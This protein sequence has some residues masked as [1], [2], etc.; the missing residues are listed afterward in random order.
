MRPAPSITYQR[1][2]R[3]DPA[4]P[5]SRECRCSQF[6]TPG[7]TTLGPFELDDD[8]A[9][10]AAIIRRDGEP[11]RRLTVGN[12]PNGVRPW[13]AGRVASLRARRSMRAETARTIDSESRGPS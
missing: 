13:V 1:V 5:P 4:R 11:D 12:T 9:Q 3:C 10:D 2:S 8:E 6:V 7:G